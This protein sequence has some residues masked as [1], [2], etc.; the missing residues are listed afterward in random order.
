[1]SKKLRVQYLIVYKIPTASSHS[2][3]IPKYIYKN[4]MLP[5]YLIAHPVREYKVC[6]TTGGPSK[7]IQRIYDVYI[8]TRRRVDNL[9]EYKF[10]G[11]KRK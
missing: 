4:K 3:I 9:F 6:L 2:N 1:M 5:E 8:P 11:I 10:E 7:S